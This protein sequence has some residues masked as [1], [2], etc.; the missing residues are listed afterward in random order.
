MD[1]MILKKTIEYIF[2][3]NPVPRLADNSNDSIEAIEL[4]GDKKELDFR[5][6]FMNIQVEIFRQLIRFT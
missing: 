3:I 5:R 2:P 6:P 1:L 4:F